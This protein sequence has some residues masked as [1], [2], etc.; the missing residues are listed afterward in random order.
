MGKYFFIFLIFLSFKLHGQTREN[1]FY[2]QDSIDSEN[3]MARKK[4]ILDNFKG[5]NYT[6]LNQRIVSDIDFNQLKSPNLIFHFKCRNTTVILI[7]PF[8]YVDHSDD[9][10]P[11]Y[12]ATTFWNKETVKL[13]RKKYHKNVIPFLIGINSF[14]LV[15]E[16]DLKKYSEN[17]SKFYSKECKNLQE[18]SRKR[19]KGVLIY[20]TGQKHYEEEFYYFP[21][22]NKKLIID[23]NS[24]ENFNSIYI[25][26]RNKP[27]KIVV[28]SFTYNL[29]ND[30]ISYQ[31]YQFK[32]NDWIKI[33]TSEKDK[34]Q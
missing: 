24:R 23:K 32:N 30:D 5:L 34:F 25:Q 2:I 21:Y 28:V 27:N 33:P 13:I 15:K 3:R 31:T 22:K 1:K 10:N 16:D 17:F 29:N 14:V 18:L 9:E 20:N 7:S 26:F 19:K 12:N 6:H 4:E 11:A 8:D